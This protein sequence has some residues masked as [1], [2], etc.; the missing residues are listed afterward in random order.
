MH[1]WF[2][3]CDCNIELPIMKHEYFPFLSATRRFSEDAGQIITL[4]CYLLWGG[5]WYLD[6]L[7]ELRAFNTWS[8]NISGLLIHEA[9]IFPLPVCSQKV[10]WRC[11]SDHY[12]VL[13]S[14]ERLT[15]RPTDS[16][17]HEYFPFLSAA[18]RLRKD[19]SQII[20]QHCY[21]LRGR[22]WNLPILQE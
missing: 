10:V 20:A 22:H 15:L 14:A 5:H 1:T 11:L 2:I 4:Y 9:W 19:S 7:Q 3:R 21:M 17:K 6:T 12:A 13:L 16:G 8:M 18:R